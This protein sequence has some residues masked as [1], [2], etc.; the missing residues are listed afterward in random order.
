MI[1]R[2]ISENSEQVVRVFSTVYR[3]VKT[4]NDIYEIFE[5]HRTDWNEKPKPSTIPIDFI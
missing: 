4:I 5:R 2:L 1:R 3:N